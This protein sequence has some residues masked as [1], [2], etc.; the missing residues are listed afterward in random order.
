MSIITL[1]TDYGIKDHFA[2]SVKGKILSA[3]PSVRVVDISHCID[4][5][6]IATASY[7][8]FGAYKNFPQETIHWVLVE[9][10]M[11]DQT[12]FLLTRFDGHYFLTANNGTISLFTT[13]NDV[14][15]IVDL[16]IPEF[17]TDTVSLFMYVSKK[18]MEK[19]AMDSLGTKVLHQDCE[20]LVE[21]RPKVSEDGNSI[22]GSVIYE[23]HYGNA[24]TNISKELFLSVQ[25]NRKY[26][27]NASRYRIH[28]INK[29]YAD[30]NTQ[31]KPIREYEGDIMLVFN[32]LGFLQI[33]IYKSNPDTVGNVRTLF[34]LTYR[35]TIIVEFNE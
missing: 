7:V 31:I 17:C 11:Y 28:R 27:V 5:Y 26:V 25:K 14:T 21:L 15:E 6:N 2:A 12:S 8:L 29:F 1:T 4:L 32:D 24:V 16:E 33:S 34:G 10:E 9:A 35:D 18:I 19:N 23:D 22:R 20:Q 13:E 30:F 3:V